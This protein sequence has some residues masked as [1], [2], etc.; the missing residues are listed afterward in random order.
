[1]MNIF[2]MRQDWCN[3]LNHV[4]INIW[5]IKSY[6]IN[7]RI[8]LERLEENGISSRGSRDVAQPIFHDT[9][10]MI[11]KKKLLCA[12]GSLKHSQKPNKQIKLTLMYWV[13]HHTNQLLERFGSSY[14][15][16]LLYCSFLSTSLQIIQYLHKRDTYTYADAIEQGKRKGNT[17]SIQGHGIL[18]KSVF[19]RRLNIIQHI[20]GDRR[21]FS[22]KNISNWGR[23]LH[24]C[25]N[26]L[27]KY[28]YIY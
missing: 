11:K 28:M 6:I 13:Y 15:R 21:I 4:V 5:R 3:W 20:I 26:W 17:Q 24:P 27:Y 23:N 19:V 9:F 1:M 10:R 8:R 22:N 7:E 12:N 14:L 18:G 25:Y 2:A 16:L